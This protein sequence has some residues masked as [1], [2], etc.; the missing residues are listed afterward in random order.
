MKGRWREQDR[1][2]ESWGDLMDAGLKSVVGC[3]IRMR[4]EALDSFTAASES[5]FE[6]CSYW[7]RIRIRISLAC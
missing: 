4:S 2:G 3:Q 5:F 1:V 7:I 6:G